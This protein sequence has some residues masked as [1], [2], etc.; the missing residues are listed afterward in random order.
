MHTPQQR[1]ARHPLLPPRHSQH[2]QLPRGGELEEDQEQA[3]VMNGPVRHLVHFYEPHGWHQPLGAV[4]GRALDHAFFVGWL[5]SASGAK[6][7]GLIPGCVGRLRGSDSPTERVALLPEGVGQPWPSAIQD[8][9][10]M[11]AL[12]WTLNPNH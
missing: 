9:E 6:T 8:S 7:A 10:C 1:V 3:A 2:A 5:W 4:Y 12:R 11:A